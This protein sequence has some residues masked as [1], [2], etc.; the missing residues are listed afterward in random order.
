LPE[1]FSDC[2]KTNAFAR[3]GCSPHDPLAR[4]PIYPI[5]NPVQIMSVVKGEIIWRRKV[6]K[7]Q[8]G[9]M[10]ERKMDKWTEW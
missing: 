10:W 8:I 7:L 2:A 1:K 9:E 5:K 6:D 3:G 4:T